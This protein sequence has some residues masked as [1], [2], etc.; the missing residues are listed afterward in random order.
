[1]YDIFE[2]VYGQSNFNGI[3]FYDS[4]LN[5]GGKKT[6]GDV[7]IV[8]GNIVNRNIVNGAPKWGTKSKI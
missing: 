6:E 5:G 8:Y 1:M 3:R 2:F 4:F 7:N